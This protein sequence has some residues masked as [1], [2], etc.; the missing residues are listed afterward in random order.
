[1]RTFNK[2]FRQAGELSRQNIYRELGKAKQAVPP[3]LG[4]DATKTPQEWYLT[5]E[6][7]KAGAKLVNAALGPPS[8][9]S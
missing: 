9:A 4:E 5:D 8:A 6:G 3:L 2:H 1:V 7:K